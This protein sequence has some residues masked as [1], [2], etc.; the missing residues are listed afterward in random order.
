M[1]KFKYIVCRYISPCEAV[2][3]IFGF[4]LYYRTPPVERLSFHLPNEQSVVFKD[5]DPLDSVINRPSVE[6][7][8]FL[9]WMECNKTSEKARKLTYV[10]FPTQFSWKPEKGIWQERVLDR[11]SIGR[12]YH[13]PPGSGEKYYLRILLNYVNGPTCYEDIRT[14]NGV[15]YAS[16]KEACYARGLLDDDKEY[17]DGITEASFW[18]TPRYLRNLFAIL[19]L[20]ESLSRPE[21]VW[22]ATWHILAEGILEEQRREL[23][24]DGNRLFFLSNY[25]KHYKDVLCISF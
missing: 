2:W 16:F 13:V 4:D 3:R 25:S 12:I 21:F 9:A 8:Q 5:N 22:N 7:S 6:K 14:F 18:G 20:S 19:L 15:L 24:I 23:G 10:E 1:S 11:F 17:I